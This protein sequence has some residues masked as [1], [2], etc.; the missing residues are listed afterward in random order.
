MSDETTNPEQSP[1]PSI[2]RRPSNRVALLALTISFVINVAFWGSFICWFWGSVS[3]A[4]GRC[5]LLAAF[6]AVVH[7]IGFRLWQRQSLQ[8]Q[9]DSSAWASRPIS[10]AYWP[11]TKT[12]LVYQGIVFILALL[13]LDMGQT[14][15]EAVTAIGAYW[16]A[17]GII[18]F[19]R[20]SS[21]T[22]SDIFMIRYGFLLMFV[23][24]AAALPFVG[25]ALG[26]W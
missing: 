11:P 6:M 18:V 7:W 4:V 13:M 20:P 17:F 12:A 2:P 14:I 24:A 26:R 21:P 25:R 15:C 8:V 10:P 5:A 1:V 23:S 9:G 19:R 22:R 3:V 16:L